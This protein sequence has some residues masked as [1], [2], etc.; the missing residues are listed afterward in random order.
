M[1]LDF[2]HLRQQ[3]DIQSILPLVATEE[4]RTLLDAF[5]TIGETAALSCADLIARS[6]SESLRHW[7]AARAMSSL[8]KDED[9]AKRALF[10]IGGKLK[11]AD[12]R[13]KIKFL[14]EK[15]YLANARGDDIEV[16]ELSRE[17]ANLQKENE[18]IFEQLFDAGVAKA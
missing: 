5:I 17:K 3:F 14:E 7:L 2:P 4:V 10:D 13:N 1:L 8:Y 6:E 9:R 18:R 16:L 12:L 11:K 15:I